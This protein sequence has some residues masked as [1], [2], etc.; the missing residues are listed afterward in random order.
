MDKNLYCQH[1]GIPF[2]NKK[3]LATEKCY[4][5]DESRKHYTK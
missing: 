2:S 4:N 3:E 1:N 5:M